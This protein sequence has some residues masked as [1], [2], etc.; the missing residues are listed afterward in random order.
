MAATDPASLLSAAKCL[1]CYGSNPNALTMM[2]VVLLQQL[3]LANNPGAAVDPKSLLAQANCLQC[4]APNLYTLTLMEVALLSQLSGGGGGGG[5]TLQV[6]QYTG[7]DPNSDGVVP[8]DPTK[9]A[10]AYKIG[11]PWYGW[12]GASWG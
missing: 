8:T 9:P 11:S 2:K 5:G 1:E 4:Y 7:T 10:I 12:N 6:F 3:V